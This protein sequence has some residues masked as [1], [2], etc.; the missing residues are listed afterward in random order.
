[1][2]DQHHVRE[3]ELVEQ[4]GEI[5][6]ERVVVVA[7]LGL[8]RL[9]VAAPVVGDRAQ[10]LRCE[11]VDLEAPDRGAERPAM[12]EDDRPAGAFVDREQAL[13]VTR[14][15][16]ARGGAR[17]RREQRREGRCGEECAAMHEHESLLRW[18]ARDAL[19]LRRASNTVKVMRLDDLLYLTY[20]LNMDALSQTF[21]ALA[22][23]TRRAILARLATAR[24]RWASWPS[25]STCRCRPCRGISRC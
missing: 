25:R 20:W 14:L 23:P 6:R 21:S 5:G 13:A 8:A 19:H 18:C 17:E 7:G 15:D 11:G 3:I 9:A 12:D 1:M 22:D 2:T 16:R 24:R 10:A 4:G